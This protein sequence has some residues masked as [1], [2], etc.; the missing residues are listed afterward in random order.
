MWNQ[1][2]DIVLRD[3]PHASGGR[4][5][6]SAIGVDSGGHYTSEVYT[7]ARSRKGKGIFALKGSSISNK[8]PISKPSK[9]DINYKGQVLKNSAEVFPCGTDTI[10]FITRGI[11]LRHCR[12]TLR[13]PFAT[14][15]A[16]LLFGHWR[17]SRSTK[18]VTQLPPRSCWQQLL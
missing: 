13:W 2:D 9:V 14:C 4:I 11:P 12:G 6:V 16:G 7:Y 15:L 17:F 18:A 1:V 5:K 3:Y 8:P 10:K